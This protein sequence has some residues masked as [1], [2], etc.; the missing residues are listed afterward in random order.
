MTTLYRGMNRAALDAAYNNVEA[1]PDFPAVLADFQARSTGLYEQASCRRDLRYGGS[2]RERY[3]WIACGQPAAPTLVFIHGGYW[4]NCAK[5]DFAFIAS[6]PL[7][8]GFN[9]VLAEYTLAPDASMTQIV[10]EIGRLLDHLGADRDALGTKGLPLVLCGH[11]AGGHLTAMYRGHPVVTSALPISALVDLEPISLSWLNDKLKL[12]A[13]EID[14]FSPLR[15]IGKGVPTMVAVGGAELPEL[16]RQ[17]DEYAAACASAGE[18]VELLHV[19][20]CTHFSILETLARRDGCLAQALVT[21][22]GR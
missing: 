17:S 4:Q 21:V 2:P 9:V 14:E 19:P 16:V 22:A 3:D 10:G 13:R 11:S 1:I 18:A 7:A 12:S 6:G 5:E 20:G 8:N 15:H